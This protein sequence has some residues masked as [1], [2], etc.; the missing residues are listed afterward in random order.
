VICTNCQAEVQ[1]LPFCPHCG[2]Q[3]HEED[4]DS[5]QRLPDRRS[6]REQPFR[7]WLVLLSLLLPIIAFGVL[8][9]ALLGFRDGMQERAR[10]TQH[11]AEI[12]YNRGLVYLEWGQNQLAEAEFEEALRL[13][14]N[15]SQ[16]EEKRQIARVKQTVT[17][18]PAPS[19]TPAATSTPLPI[20]PPTPEVVVIPVTQVLYEEA[21]AHYERR[22]WEKVISALEQLRSQDPSYR[23][24]EVTEML[25]ESHK[26]YGIQLE[27]E[28]N[29]EEAISHYDSALYLRRRDPAVEQ[30]RQQADLYI[31]AIGVWGV[32]WDTAIINLT[33]LYALAPDYRD[34]PE[35]LYEACTTAARTM[36]KHEQYCAASELL[37]QAVE[38]SA[39]DPEIVRLE[40]DTR[41]LCQVAGTLPLATPDHNG[42]AVGTVH[43]GTLLGTCYDHKTNQYALCSLRGG[44]ESPEIWIAQAEQPALTL[45]GAKLAFR[46]I[47]PTRPGL[48]AATLTVTHEITDVVTFGDVLTITTSP[49]AQ[50]PTWSPDGTR[51]AYAQ[52]DAKEGDWFILI[53]SVGVD[54][55]PRRIH[56]GEFPDWGPGG[57]LAFTT[58]S[59]ETECGI[60]VFDPA[61]WSLRRLTSSIRDRAAAWAPSAQEIAYM[62]DIG[63]STNLYIVQISTGYVRQITRN[64]FTDGFPI[65]SPDGQRIAYVTNRDDDWS[66][67]T[68]HPALGEDNR[69]IA[70]I[71]M[72]SADW[73]R[74][75]PSWIAPAL[76]FS[77]PQQAE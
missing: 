14:P 50:H 38:I 24:D 63:R 36:V 20:P 41:H 60:H 19:P 28:D 39:D 59:A 12:H 25:F 37:E 6:R 21:V 29:L 9:L 53:A 5:F 4:A 51:V 33:A 69:H 16:A 26:A 47:D 43:I 52:Y 68:L 54:A 7:R 65:W 11:Q 62:S 75:R 61:T 34:T 1:D 49:Q 77:P 23:A 70:T 48:Y 46:S 76:R 30:M 18:T 57:L 13:V 64:L 22:D 42:A 31:K 10:A 17:P 35:R 67:Y 2:H 71:G 45:D 15:Y 72:Q 27:S 40:D 66:V 32:D 3:L 73:L 55:A 74:L 8:A 44:D 56:Q 58:C